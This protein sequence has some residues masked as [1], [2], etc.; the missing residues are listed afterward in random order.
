MDKKV[1]TKVQCTHERSTEKQQKRMS[2]GQS[3]QCETKGIAEK[4]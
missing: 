1:F 4:M 2:K 3:M